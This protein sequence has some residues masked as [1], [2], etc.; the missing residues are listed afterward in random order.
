MADGSSS[1]LT[2]QT[3]GSLTDIGK[4]TWNRIVQGDGNV[5]Y[6]PFTAYDFLHSLET[7]GSV[8]A[9]V[10]WAPQHLVL[11]RDDDIVG[12]MPLYLKGHS[13]G[14]YIFDHGWADAYTRAGGRYYPK[15]LGAVPFTPATGRRLFAAPGEDIGALATA[16]AQVTEELGVS[17]LHINFCTPQEQA[18]LAKSGYLI[19]TGQQYRFEDDGYGTWAG[20]L[21]ALASRKRKALRKE[22]ESIAQTGLS[23]DWLSGGDIT[24]AHLDQFWRFYQDTGSRKWGTPYL[25]RTFFS[26]I[27][28]GMADKLLFI[29]ARRGERYIAG[30]MNLIGGDTLYGR[31]WGC[32][33]HIPFLHFELCYYQAIDYALAHGLKYVEAGAQG[34]HKIARGYRPMTTYSAHWLPNPS[35][36]EAVARFL[37]A[38]REQV[39][40]DI[41]YLSGFTPFK[42]EG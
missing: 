4:T 20:F 36:R 25:T 13:Q 39:D 7:S 2:A 17:S 30:A 33:E 8:R 19:R 9:E 28:E 38:E 12:V 16:A 42:K 27:R 15:L 23:I 11:S 41:D 24:E 6:C 26:Q 29:M 31:Y 3:V 37:E 14:E 22:R 35:F 21:E 5:P 40:A 18:A 34:E 10:G 1:P 32:T